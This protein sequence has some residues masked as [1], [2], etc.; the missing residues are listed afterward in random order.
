MSMIERT[1]TPII[2]EIIE[3]LNKMAFVS[4]PRQVGKTTLAK[5]YQEHFGQSVY[6]NWD[7]IPHRKKL[8]ADPL[9]FQKENRD[10]EK[11]FLVVFDEIHK[12]VRWKNYLKGIYDE[13][14]DEFRF[15]ITGSGRLELFKKGGD[16]LLGRYFS[17]PL[18]PLSMGELTNKLA[19]LSEFKKSLETPPASS[20]ETKDRYEQ[21]FRFSGFPEPFSRESVAFY[22]RWFSERKTLLLREDI[23]DA[24]AIR[25][26][27]LLEHLAHLIPERI[28][29]PLSINSLKGDVGVAF[30]TIRDWV[31]ILEQFFYLFRVAP[32]TGRLTRTLRKETKVYLYDWVEIEKE[33]FRFENFVALHLLKATRL[34]KATGEAD[35]GLH[36][37]RD[38]EKREVDFV[39]TEKGKPFCLV[40]CNAREEEISPHLVYFQK[41]L[42]VPFA[43]QLVHK[44]GVC[45]KLRKETLTQWVISADRWLSALP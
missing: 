34:W 28:G 13:S 38:K 31:L 19:G 20:S 27:S 40:E 8:L 35:A 45:K 5:K 10:P 4:G 1:S 11:P 44:S 30:E 43:I 32:F 39:L 42:A 23:R 9:F 36:Y 41:K 25:E 22:N 17:V 26:I 15:L 18:L 37:L 12:Y 7:S 33:S 6:V 16:S 14:K 29:S 21:L 2:G 3:T 24:T